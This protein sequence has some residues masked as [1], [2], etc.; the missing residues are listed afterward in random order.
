MQSGADEHG[1]RDDEDANDVLPADLD[2]R[3]ALAAV[4]SRESW[5]ADAETIQRRVHD[6]I[7]PDRLHNVVARLR[8]GQTYRNVAEVWAEVSREPPQP[9]F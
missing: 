5:P 1:T 7:G 6:S 3:A 2:D 4:L 9:L 8:K